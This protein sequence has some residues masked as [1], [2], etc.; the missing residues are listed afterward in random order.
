MATLFALV[1]P[2][3]SLDPQQFHDHWRH[4]HGTLAAQM[5]AVRRY[6]QFHR[7]DCPEM[8][9]T[10]IAAAGPSEGMTAMDLPAESSLISLA[11]DPV[12]R[13]FVARDE[14]RLFDPEP[15][16]V[17]LARRES[18]AAVEPIHP[19]AAQRGADR[20]P[21]DLERA[22]A[23]SAS[24]LSRFTVTESL[25]PDDGITGIDI[26]WWPTPSRWRNGICAATDETD[27]FAGGAGHT[28]PGWTL[29]T[30]CEHGR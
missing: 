2:A 3:A 12:H 14:Q 7:L 8:P 5:D 17:F 26:L 11:D 25:Y 20:P 24:W 22:R 16:R 13:Q 23:L 10:L 29:V 21:R 4:P 9:P 27:G 1:A 6:D 15:L 18:D 28:G 30:R 19:A